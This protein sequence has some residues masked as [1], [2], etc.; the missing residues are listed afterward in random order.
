M[1]ADPTLVILALG[2]SPCVF[3]QMGIGNKEVQ[4][5]SPLSN[6]YKIDT[7]IVKK[8][9]FQITCFP[10]EIHY[11]L[12]LFFKIFT[13]QVFQAPLIKIDFWWDNSRNL[14]PPYYFMVV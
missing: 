2:F 14:K 7:L 11:I 8:K 4:V 12:F 13:V 6:Y 9:M 10:Y 3:W 1:F 5:L